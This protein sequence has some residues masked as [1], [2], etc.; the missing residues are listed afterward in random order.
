MDRREGANCEEEY[1]KKIGPMVILLNKS[2]PNHKGV[3]YTI[4]SIPSLRT[5]HPTHISRT[6]VMVLES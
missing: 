6:A 2:Q 5:S 1:I 4:C 3:V